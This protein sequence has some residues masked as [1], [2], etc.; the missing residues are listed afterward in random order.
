[1]PTS[2]NTTIPETR[3]ITLTVITAAEL[4]KEKGCQSLL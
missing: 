3:E 4:R 1:M 2:D